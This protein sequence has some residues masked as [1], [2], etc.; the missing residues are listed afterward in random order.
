[1]RVIVKRSSQESEVMSMKG[2]YGIFSNISNPN[3]TVRPNSKKI[4]LKIKRLTT[5]EAF[6]QK[7]I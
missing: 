1:M 2:I 5:V 3:F 4:R 7:L 6:S